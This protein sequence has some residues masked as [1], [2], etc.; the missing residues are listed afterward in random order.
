MQ[1]FQS[2]QLFTV[3][4]VHG[5]KKFTRLRLLERPKKRER[6][7][8]K[9]EN[10]LTLGRTKPLPFLTDRKTLKRKLLSVTT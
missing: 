9:L 8:E 1:G 3:S 10:Y 5:G 2:P 6:E 7:R 4:N